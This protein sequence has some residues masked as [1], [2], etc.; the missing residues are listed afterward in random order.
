MFRITLSPVGCLAV[1]HFSTL[2]NKLHDF[3]ICVDL[4]SLQILFEIFLILRRIPWDIIIN[5]DKR[6]QML[7]KTELSIFMPIYD[8]RR[9]VSCEEAD[10]HDKANCR[11]LELLREYAL[12]SFRLIRL[13]H[14]LGKGRT[15]FIFTKEFGQF[16]ALLH[17]CKA[18]IKTGPSVCQ[19]MRIQEGWTDLYK[20]RYL[21]ISQE[22]I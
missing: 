3:R 13:W 20:I 19:H 9:V 6:R 8:G 4:F 1:P 12:Q 11:F 16:Q 18:P 10:G 15:D 22:V 17:P 7:V 14:W 21:A 2:S 5:V